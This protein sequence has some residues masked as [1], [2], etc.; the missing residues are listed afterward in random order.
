M[1]SYEAGPSNIVIEA[2]VY[3]HGKNAF[4]VTIGHIDEGVRNTKT[5]ITRETPTAINQQMAMVVS[6]GSLNAH[7]DTFVNDVSYIG[8]KGSIQLSGSTFNNH[9]GTGAEYIKTVT[10]AAWWIKKRPKK[11]KSHKNYRRTSAAVIVNTVGTVSIAASIIESLGNVALHFSSVINNGTVTKNTRSVAVTTVSSHQNSVKGSG[12]VTLTAPTASNLGG[13]IDA[14]S[15]STQTDTLSPLYTAGSVAG[16]GTVLN[17]V[18]IST[19]TGNSLMVLDPLLIPGFKLPGSH[20]LFTINTNPDHPYLIETNP[21][22]TNYNNFTSSDYLLDRLDWSGDEY[23]RRIGDGFYEQTLI[24]NSLQAQTGSRY[25]D[26]LA[27]AE[28]F[29]QLMD[30]AVQ[31]TEDLDLSVGVALSKDQVNRLTRSMIWME[32]RIVDGV[33][34]LVPVVYLSSNRELKAEDGALIAGKNVAILGNSDVVNTGVI[35]ALDTLS[36]SSVTGSIT[37]RQGTLVAGN[38]LQV[39]AAKN[40]SNLSA[41]IEGKTLS[42]AAGDSIINETLIENVGSIKELA[43]SHQGARASL[44]AEQTLE[45]TAGKNITDKA[46]LITAGDALTLSAGEEVRVESQEQV[47]GY[48]FGGGSHYQT[49][50]RRDHLTSEL[51]S[52]GDLTVASGGN[53]LLQGASVNAANNLVVNAADNINLL[54]VAN[55]RDESFSYSRK[56]SYGSSDKRTS[57]ESSAVNHQS[58]ALISGADLTLSSGQNLLAYGSTVQAV[59]NVT[60]DA[61]ENIKLIAAVDQENYAYQEKKENAV[62]YSNESHGYQQQNAISSSINSGGDLTVN[63]VGNIHLLGSELQAEGDMIIGGSALTKASQASI[64]TTGAENVIVDTIELTNEQWHE[65]SKGFKGPVKELIK[66]ASIGFAAMMGGVVDA[67][68]M[69]V[70][71]SQELRTQQTIQNGSYIA[72]ENLSIES[73]GLTRLAGAEVNVTENLIVNSGDIQIDAVADTREHYQSSTTESIKSLGMAL[74]KDEV[75]LG[76]IEIAKEK[77]SQLV[78]TTT[79]KGSQLSAGNIS[80]NADRNVDITASQITTEQDLDINAGDNLTVTGKQNQ[81]AVT[82]KYSKETQTITAAVRNAYV[83]VGFAVDA[84]AEAEKGVSTARKSLS[85]AKQKVKD[86]KLRE[87]DIKYYEINLA[88]ATA[89]LGQAVIALGLSGATAAGTTA[90]A[91]FYVSGSAVREKTE[92]ATQTQT[93]EWNGSQVIAGGNAALSSGQQLALTGSDLWVGGNADLSSQNILINAGESTASSK[94]E[95]HSDNQSISVSY[96]AK[97]LSGNIQAGFKNSDADSES[98]HYR[99]S[100]IV[101]TNLSSHSDTLTVSGA[102]LQADHINIATDT[103]VVES[104]QNYDRSNSQ[105]RGANA[106]AGFGSSGLTSINAGL[107]KSDSESERRWVDDQTQIIGSESVVISAKDTTLTGAL[108]AN[109]TYDEQ[110]QWVDQ[111]NLTLNTD[112]LTANHLYDTDTAKSEGFNLSVSVNIDG[113]ASNTDKPANDSAGPQTGQTTIGGHYNGHEKNQTTYATVG[114]GKI[115]AGGETQTDIAGLN[116]DISN[117]QEV[118]QDIEIGGLNASVTVDHR[119][120]SEEGHESIANDFD[121]TGELTQETGSDFVKVARIENDEGNG[122]YYA[123]NLLTE[124][125]GGLLAELPILIGQGDINNK[126]IQ[127]VTDGSKYMKGREDD[128]QSIEDS[129]LYLKLPK[130][131]QKLLEGKNYYITKVDV[132]INAENAT[133]Q[134][135]TNG[136][137]ND[138]GLAI[139]N[140]MQQTSKTNKDNEVVGDVAFTLNYNPTHGFLSDAL[141]SGLDNSGFWTTGIAKQT[142]GF[143]RDVTTARGKEGSN[144]NNHSQGNILNRVGLDYINSKGDYEEGGF[145]SRG[146]FID[147]SKTSIEKQGEGIPTWAGFGSPVNTEVMKKMVEQDSGFKYQG[148]FTHD[149]DY[150]GEGI[151]GNKGENEQVKDSYYEKLQLLEVVDLFGKDSPHST[152]GC[153]EYYNAKCGEP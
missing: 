15:A 44:S 133:Y 62:K 107:E 29:E 17:T 109:A 8:A 105:T 147:E 138:E 89:N 136:M 16:L 64:A 131:K 73:E 80:L 98:L 114:N 84:V 7:A 56:G 90:T 34:V 100:Q 130:D 129:E 146:Y 123:L 23:L 49:L 102:A 108:I 36:V 153:S 128:F 27:G 116:R 125:T 134:N 52:G 2:P 39:D 20:G 57:S 150:V 76:G 13:S 93:G 92:T 113:Q 21:L 66:V 3:S 87:K 110:G 48:Q 103:L 1:G 38:L 137:M 37:N 5:T 142:G 99:N 53:I 141:E 68:A 6:G 97:G 61:A 117:A 47:T 127:V 51:Q 74:K 35:E 18:V 94:S 60:I 69:E 55:T 135:A 59:G 143:I 96:G 24:E 111:G 10:E 81:H 30:N 121:K 77:E 152:Y 54:A 63:T 26:G 9:E 11:W 4:N 40:I 45:L 139:I 22:L 86:G 95:T 118:T 101:A 122:L 65:K 41:R 72:A 119:L 144:F 91:G 12:T 140:A 132:R 115:T 151:G 42:L 58:T 106:G 78:S 33:K 75:S 145:K 67:P 126:Q 124:N 14:P 25:L 148:M 70:A 79:W 46:G 83:D 71:S 149:G 82:D 28:M 50:D 120:F 19:V 104:L 112:T 32:T 88:A 85:E 31:T 43:F